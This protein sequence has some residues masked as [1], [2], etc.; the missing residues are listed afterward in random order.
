MTM[1]KAVARDLLKKAGWTEP[2]ITMALRIIAYDGARSAAQIAPVVLAFADRSE[3]AGEAAVYRALAQ[4][5]TDDPREADA[6]WAL[7]GW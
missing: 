4:R 5:L 7:R 3:D 2:Q 6:L 1:H